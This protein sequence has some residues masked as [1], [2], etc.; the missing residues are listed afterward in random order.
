LDRMHTPPAPLKGGVRDIEAIIQESLRDRLR[1]DID[2]WFVD[3]DHS[4][5]YCYGL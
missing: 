3:K 5:K 2:K 4:D 1:W